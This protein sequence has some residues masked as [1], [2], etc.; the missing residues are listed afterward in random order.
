MT[1]PGRPCR[2]HYDYDGSNIVK[3][4][5]FIP[6]YYWQAVPV[7]AFL[8]DDLSGHMFRDRDRVRR[9]IQAR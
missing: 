7:S 2:R 3:S 9:A 1:L 8:S 6:G 5:G 4:F